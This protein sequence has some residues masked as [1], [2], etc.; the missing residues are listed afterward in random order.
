VDN[1]GQPKFCFLAKSWNKV[2][3]NTVVLKQVF[4]QKGDNEFIDMLNNVRVGNLNY[5][6]IEAFQKLDR[7]INYTDGIEPTQLYPT[8]K[9]VLMANQAKLNS[10]PGKVYTFQ[11]KDPENPFLVS[12]LDNNLMVDKVLHLKT[13]AQVMCVK[14]FTDELVNG[15]LGTVLFMATRK[16]YMKFLEQYVYIDAEDQAALAEM[17]FVCNRIGESGG[18]TDQE[19]AFFDNI[20]L[21]RQSFIQSCC[22]L[23]SQEFESTVLPVVNFS[24]TGRGKQVVMVEKEEFKI[25]KAGQ[26][27]TTS[28]FENTGNELVRE[29]LPL[30]LSWAMSIHKA[31][32]QTLDR[33]KIDLGRSFANGQAY[34]ALSRATCKSRLEIKN[35]RKDKV[36]TSEHVRKYYESLG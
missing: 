21:Q 31:Q 35:F 27:S 36:K 30:I 1:S 9:E 22:H 18:F 6:T 7:Q 26:K 23:A 28:S 4:R 3:E 15:T 33:V 34:V 14:N 19:K 2:I 32:G 24:I 25:E 29:Q 17:R 8:L 13:G 11:A 10:L 16:L 5:E 20:P 12:M